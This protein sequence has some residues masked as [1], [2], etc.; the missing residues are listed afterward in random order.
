LSQPLKADGGW[1]LRDGAGVWAALAH[2]TTLLSL[3]DARITNAFV[4]FV[5][6]ER[7]RLKVVAR[8]FCSPVRRA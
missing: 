5:G 8:E 1:R 4:R 7:M 6:G 3:R 2:V